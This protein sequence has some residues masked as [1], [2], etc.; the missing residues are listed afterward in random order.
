MKNKYFKYIKYFTL[1]PLFISLTLFSN[2]PYI[3]LYLS[4][5][6]VYLITLV[7]FGAFVV[8]DVLGLKDKSKY[9]TKYKKYLF[10]ILL[11]IFLTIFSRVPYINIFLSFWQPFLIT[12]VIVVIV[13]KIKQWVNYFVGILLI[14]LALI[15]LLL[16][17]ESVAEEFG[18]LVYFLLLLGFIQDFSSYIVDLKRKN[19][20]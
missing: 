14:I 8:Y 19:K 20:K 4:S 15:F 9:L 10:I 12:W 17:K 3:N 18:A 7:L 1:M 2:F 11:F 16:G 13:L 5:W 6:V